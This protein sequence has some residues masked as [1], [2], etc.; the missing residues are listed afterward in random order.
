MQQGDQYAAAGSADRVTQRNGTAVDVDLVG[1]PAQLFRHAQCLCG[2][3]F[4]G[5]H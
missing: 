1:T 5:F 3:G 2:E 4:V